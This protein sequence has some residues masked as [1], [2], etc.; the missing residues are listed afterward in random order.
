[1]NNVYLVCRILDCKY[2]DNCDCKHDDPQIVR[3]IDE[4]IRK[5]NSKEKR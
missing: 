1:M 2:N 4:D 5:C 3:T